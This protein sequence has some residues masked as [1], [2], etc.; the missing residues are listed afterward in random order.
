MNLFKN[1]DI[2]V[3][4]GCGSIGSEIVRQLL[5]F[6]PKRIRVLDN[7]ESGHF[8][9]NQRIKTTKV[10]ITNLLGDIR[11]RDRVLFAFEGVDIVFHAA[12][13]KHVP[14]CE[15]NPFQAVDTNV[16]GTE[17]VV[18]A[19]IKN[20]IDIMVGISTDKAVNPINTMGATKLLSEKI[21]I[22]APIGPSKTR[23]SAVR[24][25]NVLNSVGSVIP[26]FYEQIKEGGP[27]TI[28]S[29][30]M[31]RFF[32][33]MEDAINLVLKTAEIMNG[34]EV[35]VL[36]MDALK[37]IDLA[38]IM[39]EELAPH[40][41]H[42]EIKIKKIGLRPGEKIDEALITKEEEPFIQ[43]N[44]DL[45]ILNNNLYS[46]SVHVNNVEHK[47]YDSGNIK[48]LTKEQIRKKIKPIMEELKK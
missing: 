31:T 40:Y 43:E 25:G 33:T 13:L 29:K 9:L 21:I 14:F 20:N 7:H 41:G 8:F 48:L 28:T 12:A 44:E 24:F 38:E 36:K 37:I 5:K 1:K 4:G 32:M 34:G 35:F 15:Y 42:K 19:C 3:T 23:M 22:N 16:I 11:D 6:E 17:N 2:M 30:R 45:F 18:A 39:I 46:P 26:I 47:N 27:L 10:Q